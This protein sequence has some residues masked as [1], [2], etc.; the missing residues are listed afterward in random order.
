MYGRGRRS[1]S[2]Q[3]MVG[4]SP[5]APDYRVWWETELA[6]SMADMKAATER[7]D[8]RIVKLMSKRVR[9]AKAALNE[10]AAA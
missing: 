4:P 5:S 9:E 2:A 1:S 6:R 3:V 7:G 10:R 8:V